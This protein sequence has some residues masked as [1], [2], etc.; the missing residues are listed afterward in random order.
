[1]KFFHNSRPSPRTL[2]TSSA[3]VA[4]SAGA[5][6]ASTS[7]NGPNRTYSS[8][9]F[10]FVDN[11]QGSAAAVRELAAELDIGLGLEDGEGETI[12]DLLELQLSRL[13]KTASGF[14]NCGL[15]GIGDEWNWYDL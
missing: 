9:G 14:I 4:V 6:T 11:S 7:A 15:N 5:T 10:A 2:T 8:S 3:T 12:S 13:N 1:M